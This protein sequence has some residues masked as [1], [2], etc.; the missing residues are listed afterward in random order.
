MVGKDSPAKTPAGLA[1]RKL[2]VSFGSDSHLDTLLWVKDQKLDGNLELINVAPSELATALANKSVDAIV[3]RQPQVLRLQEQSGA[4]ILHTWPFRFVSIV[5]TK[6]I[7]DHPKALNQYLT[8]LRESLLFIAR[9]QQQAATWF[10]AH[11][12]I[13][14]KVVMTV[15][16]EDANYS[17]KSIADIDV[18]VTPA[19]RALVGKW[20]ADALAYKMIRRPVDLS[21]L[22]H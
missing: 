8:S 22:F 1:G 20:T 13:D 5:K 6:F 4:R 14:P 11:L 15:S 7:A 2:G 19:A 21:G 12:R 10:G 3:I 9:N 18:S 16:R 17:A